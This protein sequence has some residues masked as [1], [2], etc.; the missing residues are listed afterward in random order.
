MR[1]SRRRKSIYHWR[2]QEKATD[3]NIMQLLM[4]SVLGIIICLV[5]LAG[6]TWAWF[7]DT[8]EVSAAPLRSAEHWSKTVIKNEG[9]TVDSGKDGTYNLTPNTLYTV[10]LT[11]AGNTSNGGFS[12]VSVDGDTYYTKRMQKNDSITFTVCSENGRIT[13]DSGWQDFSSESK[14]ALLRALKNGSESEKILRDGTHI[15]KGTI[16]TEEDEEKP[17]DAAQPDNADK[18]VIEEHPKQPSVEDSNTASQDEPKHESKQDEPAT[19]PE[20]ATEPTEQQDTEVSDNDSDNEPQAP[21]NNNTDSNAGENVQD[22]QNTQNN[23]NQAE[24]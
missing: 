14:R 23:T 15:G 19:S 1:G 11:S 12:A 3:A 16:P 20:P 4:P 13:I 6:M 10:E 8:G 9:E 5:C 24:E 21:S 7:T 2:K 22:T 18:T 17:D